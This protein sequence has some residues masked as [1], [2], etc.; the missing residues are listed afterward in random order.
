MTKTEA[1]DTIANQVIVFAKNTGQPVTKDSIWAVLSECQAGHRGSFLAASA[2]TANA[3]TV[4]TLV[5]KHLK[6]DAHLLAL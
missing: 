3:K 1:A 5:R 4:A 6:Y 2:R